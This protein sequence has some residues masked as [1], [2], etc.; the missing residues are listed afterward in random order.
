MYN[1]KVFFFGE[2]KKM[3]LK[4]N[5]IGNVINQHK[6]YEFY[7]NKYVEFENDN[8]FLFCIF[9]PSLMIVRN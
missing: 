3:C 8:Q 2:I 5:I 1:N 7:C 6:V 9:N 4:Q